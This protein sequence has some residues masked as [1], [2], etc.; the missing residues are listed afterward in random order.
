MRSSSAWRLGGVGPAHSASSSRKYWSM[1]G[2]CQTRVR[3]GADPV[4]PKVGHAAGDQHERPGATADGLG[5]QG[6]LHLAL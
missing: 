6:E 5:A 3:A 2:A 4:L 1:A